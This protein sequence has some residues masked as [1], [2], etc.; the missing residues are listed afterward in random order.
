MKRTNI[1]LAIIL[2]LLTTNI[3]TIIAVKEKNSSLA[4]EELPVGEQAIESRMGFFFG[5]MGFSEKQLDK[6]EK[7][8]RD[9]NNAAGEIAAELSDLRHEIVEE[10]SSAGSNNEFLDS[11]IRQFGEKHAQLKRETVIFYK[12][13]ESVCDSSQK[14]KLEFMF[15][16]ML[17]PEGLI[18]GRGR[19]R[20]MGQGIGRGM[21]RGRSEPPGRGRGRGRF[22]E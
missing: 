16:D 14:E 1:Y 5:E 10:V 18:Y 19:G 12:Q 17:D 21:G 7:Y 11:V 4:A 13:L 8:N 2:F 3:V 9:Y 6:V 15:R 22:Q 20:G